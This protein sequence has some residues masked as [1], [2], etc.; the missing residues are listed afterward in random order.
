M[1]VVVRFTVHEKDDYVVLA[2]IF[3]RGNSFFFVE[4]HETIGRSENRRLVSM[5]FCAR[6]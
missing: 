3:I 6:K 4:C 2:S 1:E 5:V